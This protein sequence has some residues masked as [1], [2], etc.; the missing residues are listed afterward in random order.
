MEP[1]ITITLNLDNYTKL[2]ATLIEYKKLLAELRS[3]C[4][5]D[6]DEWYFYNRDWYYVDKLEQVIDKSLKCSS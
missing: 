5:K 3:K 1:I 4:P 6:S 2:N